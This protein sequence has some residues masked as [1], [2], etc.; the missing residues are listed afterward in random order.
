MRRIRSQ[1]DFSGLNGILAQ[2]V[3]NELYLLPGGSQFP[4][5]ILV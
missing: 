2:I 3:I 5:L 4:L 1:L